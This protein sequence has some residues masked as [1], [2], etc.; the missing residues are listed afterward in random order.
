MSVRLMMIV[1]A[2]GLCLVSPAVVCAQTTNQDAKPAAAAASSAD[3]E[4]LLDQAR[5]AIA[6]THA[7]SY[8]ATVEGAGALAGKVPTVKAE[9]SGARADAG[10][11]KLYTKGT[12]TGAD[13]GHR[14][15]GRLRRRHRP[16]QP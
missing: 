14:I 11:W 6:D 1:A 10:G 5:K 12:S 4:K 13:A 9:V 16:L 8:T 2:A 15:R 3:A 7:I